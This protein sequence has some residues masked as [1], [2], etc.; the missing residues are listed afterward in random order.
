MVPVYALAYVVIGFVLAALER[1]GMP[2]LTG[3]ILLGVL[4]I[5]T[6]EWGFGLAYGAMTLRPWHYAHGWASDFS[7]GLVTLYYL[8][9]WALFVVVAERV[10]RIVS[11]VAPHVDRAVRHEVAGLRGVGPIP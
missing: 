7:G 2:G 9:A 8:P 5:Y 6:L 3:R 11:A 4:L 10:W 1:R